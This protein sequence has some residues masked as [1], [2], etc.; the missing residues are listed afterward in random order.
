MVELVYDVWALWFGPVGDMVGECLY[1][2]F[3]FVVLVG[4]YDD[5]CGFVDY[6]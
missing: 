2:C 6:E 1:E 3:V 5:V 4:V